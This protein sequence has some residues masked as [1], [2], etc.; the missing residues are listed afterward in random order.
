MLKK[1]KYDGFFGGLYKRNETFLMLSA[2]IVLI[3]IFLG[4]ALASFLSPILGVYLVILKI[5]SFR[6]KSN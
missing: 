3:S 2:V 6:D 1:E 4:Y 5:G